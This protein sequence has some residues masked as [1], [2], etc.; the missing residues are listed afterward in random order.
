MAA[1]FKIMYSFLI[2]GIHLFPCYLRCL[3]EIWYLLSFRSL[4]CRITE[5]N[6]DSLSSVHQLIG[7]D[8]ASKYLAM[9]FQH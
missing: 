5:R 8:I 7:Q 6:L 9:L 3:T 2:L 1:I 4:L